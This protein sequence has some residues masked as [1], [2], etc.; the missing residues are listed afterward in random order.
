MRALLAFAAIV[1]AA[2]A[3]GAHSGLSIPKAQD[4]QLGGQQARPLSVT[5]RNVG[6]VSV[7][8]FARTGSQD[9]KIA[10]VAPGASFAHTFAV[11]EAAILRNA[12][13]TKLAKLSVDF[14]D[15]PSALTMSYSPARP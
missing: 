7:A 6:S 15:N 12:S 4:F 11:G 3:A 2:P 5:G 8:V 14:D 1:I 10:D 9:A 13:A